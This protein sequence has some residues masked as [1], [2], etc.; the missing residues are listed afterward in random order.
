M[1]EE[2]SLS[3]S[4]EEALAGLE[5]I[6]EAMEHENL[7]LEELV[8]HYEKGAALLSRCESILQSARGRIELITLRNQNEIAL[9]ANSEAA[10]HEALSD[11]SDDDNDIRLF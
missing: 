4:F 10:N 3:P 2:V 7:P 9:D 6:V 5:A 8:T 1:E 11:D